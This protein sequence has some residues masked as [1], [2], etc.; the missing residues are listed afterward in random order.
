[1]LFNLPA[2]N[3]VPKPNKAMSANDQRKLDTWATNPITGGPKRKPTKLIVETEARANWGGIV[4]D[5]PASP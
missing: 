4:L 5:L 2:S 3:V 1:M